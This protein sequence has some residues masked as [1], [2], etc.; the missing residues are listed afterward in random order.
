MK[1]AKVGCNIINNFSWIALAEA[2]FI[3]ISLFI[4]LYIHKYIQKSYIFAI[5]NKSVHIRMS[6]TSDQHPN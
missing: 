2:L 3:F 1:S 5:I 6:N 4:M